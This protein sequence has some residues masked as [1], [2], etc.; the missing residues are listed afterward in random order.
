MTMNVRK[1]LQKH[2]IHESNETE[3]GLMAEVCEHEKETWIPLTQNLMTS[4]VSLCEEESAGCNRSSSNK[5]G[6]GGG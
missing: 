6:S 1:M 4:Q 2:V 3:Q 5:G